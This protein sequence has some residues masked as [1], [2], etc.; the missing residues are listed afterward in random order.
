MPY[1]FVLG[2][3]TMSMIW[4]AVASGLVWTF[5]EWI[6]TPIV[7]M[8][9]KLQDGAI[10]FGFYF[11]ANFVALWITARLAPVFG[12]GVTSFVWLV[13]LALIAD[14]L[15]FIIWRLCNFKKMK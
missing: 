10:M 15:Q 4:A 7:K 13:L 12:F 8:V 1:Y 6:S 3:K 2:N 11:V 9:M 5:L 14:T